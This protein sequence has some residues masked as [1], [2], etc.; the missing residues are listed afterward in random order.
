MFWFKRCLKCNGDLYDN[1]D[2]HGSYVACLQCG[3]HLTPDQEHAFWQEAL[4]REE[5]NSAGALQAELA[6]EIMTGT[7]GAIRSAA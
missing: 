5:V 7:P 1:R 3:H 6:A 2:M 4:A